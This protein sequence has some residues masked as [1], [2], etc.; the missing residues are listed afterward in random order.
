[1][2]KVETFALIKIVGLLVTML[3]VGCSSSI[4][5]QETN[6]EKTDSIEEEGAEDYPT[7]PI[8][9][10]IP[11]DPGSGGDTFARQFIRAAEERLGES[12]VPDNRPGDGGM[13]GSS[14]VLDQEPD[15]Q[16]ILTHSSTLAYKIAAGDN[17]FT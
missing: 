16:T 6:E 12:I 11:L 5:G 1:M 17:T 3:M 13:I 14:Y 4:D 9:L 15:G 10:V 2:R 7:G 8:D